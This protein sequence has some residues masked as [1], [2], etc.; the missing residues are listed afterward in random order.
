VSVIIPAHNE[1]ALLPRC[2]RSLVAQDFDG[3]MRVVVV[4]NGSHD[5]TDQ[6]A[7]LW[8]SQLADAGHEVVILKLERGNKSEALNAGDALAVGKCFIYL[9]A[10]VELSPGCV[11][12]VLEMMEEP[13]VEMCAPRLVVA[14]SRAWVTRRYARV[15]TSLPWVSEDA[16]GGGFYA[17]SAEARRRWGRFPDVLAED[18]FV[19]AQFRRC[20]RRIADSASFV[21]HLPDG[22]SDL[23]RIR[24]RWLSG[25][26]Q[27]RNDV[28]GDW[29][30][31]AF[32]LRSRVKALLRRPGLWPDLPLYALV[33]LLARWRARRRVTLGTQI[34]E[35]GR[36]QI[37]AMD[38]SELAPAGPRE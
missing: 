30:R 33:N 17:V 25:V 12:A 22:W 10:D 11:R 2:L 31:A 35:R 26:R 24:T 21:I 34:W 6:V 8:A 29:G 23:L 1:A 9:D 37:E 3:V 16:I 19:Q 13:G 4:D 15:W 38:D 27:L 28:G 7:S 14:R 36:P 32:P 18:T 5:G 20:E